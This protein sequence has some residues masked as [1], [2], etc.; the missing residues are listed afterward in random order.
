MNLSQQHI[1]TLRYFQE[2]ENTILRE[3][4]LGDRGNYNEFCRSAMKLYRGGLLASDANKPFIKDLSTTGDTYSVMGPLHLTLEGEEALRIAGVTDAA[5]TLAGS[6]TPKRAVTPT[7]MFAFGG[8]AVILAIAY[9]I[10]DGRGGSIEIDSLGMTVKAE[11][12]N[13]HRDSD[14][15]NAAAQLQASADEGRQSEKNILVK[16][17]PAVSPMGDLGWRSGHKHNFCVG[18]GYTSVIATGEYSQGNFCYE[19][20]Q[21]ACKERIR[22]GI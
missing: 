20:D 12:K 3:E 15:S 22:K 2:H 14:S 1:E 7:W 21:D 18:L 5:G 11:G 13:Q 19:G 6:N 9:A 10:V 8:L 16:K 4:D 17:C